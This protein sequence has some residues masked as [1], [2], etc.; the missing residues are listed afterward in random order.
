MWR[1]SRDYL[2]KGPSETTRFVYSRQAVPRNINGAEAI[3]LVSRAIAHFRLQNDVLCAVT[4]PP[5]KNRRGK[6]FFLH[7]DP[8]LMLYYRPDTFSHQHAS[9]MHWATWGGH[10]EIVKL[11]LEHKV[12]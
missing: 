7:S 12:S 9:A 4:R 8:H 5:C 2:T 1:S 3:C 10:T 11:L 6:N